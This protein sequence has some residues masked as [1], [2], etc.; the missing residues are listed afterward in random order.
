MSNKSFTT[1]G[2]TRQLEDKAEKLEGELGQIRDRHSDLEARFAEISRQLK[3]AQEKLEDV[4]NDSDAQRQHLKN[5]NE[6]LRNDRD[7]AER[8]CQTLLERA[9]DLDKRLRNESEEKDLLH[10]RHDTLTSESHALQ[11]DIAKANGRI[12]KLQFD[13]EQE[14]KCALENDKRLRNEAKVEFDR[15]TE[16]TDDACRRLE[17]KESQYISDKDYWEA[18]HRDLQSQKAKAEE[19]ANGLQ[20]TVDTLRESQ[21]TLPGKEMKLQ[22]A[23]ESEKKRHEDE[24]AVLLRQIQ[25]LKDDLAEKREDLETLRAEVAEA[26]DDLRI[27]ERDRLDLE[28]KVQELQDEVDVLQNGV[29][30]DENVNLQLNEVRE[31]LHQVEGDRQT[32]QEQLA[33]ASASSRDLHRALDQTEVERDELRS[34]TENMQAHFDKSQKLDQE[35]IELLSR[36]R[37][38]QNHILREKEHAE[39]CLNDHIRQ[40]ASEEARLVAERAE[41]ERKV[42]ALTKDRERDAA[43][44]KA[45][46]QRLQ[47][48]VEQLEG[49]LQHETGHDGASP[50]L[51]ILREDLSQ[52]RKKETALIQRE[53]TLRDSLRDLKRKVAELERQAHDSKVSRLAY[54]SPK[55]S[56]AESVRMEELNELRQQLNDSR[57]QLSDFRT[58]SRKAEETLQRKLIDAQR[59]E[60]AAL[61]A[62]SEQIEVLEEELRKCRKEKEQQEI[63]ASEAQNNEKRLQNRFKILETSLKS[64]HE[65][66]AMD[67]TMANERK[68][69]HEMLKSAKLE[70]EDLE[71]QV[72]A[73]DMQI[74]AYVRREKH[75]VR[76][77]R[78]AREERLTHEEKT[79]SLSSE[80]D[81]LQLEYDAALN[82]FSRK[83]KSL[84]AERK[85]ILGCARSTNLYQS[86]QDENQRIKPGGLGKV[87]Q[88]LNTKE[89]QHQL[90]LRGLMKQMQWLKERFMRESSFRENLQYE[91]RYLSLE[92]DMY[93][94]W[95]VP[96]LPLTFLNAEMSV[97][98]I[99]SISISWQRWCPDP[100]F[101][102]RRSPASKLPSS[103]SLLL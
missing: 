101:L 38:E 13:V 31:N 78:K 10:S 73:R 67:I 69:L 88:A 4:E 62:H 30:E 37:Q 56:V 41:L 79:I 33:L 57:H 98:A 36:L 24:E 8:K 82:K 74:K 14:K 9:Q 45:R 44:S 97:T 39:D 16:E 60:H 34:R 1:K 19:R 91:K 43:T 96:Y 52:A 27:T 54:G 75:L 2:L 51:S 71:L 32:L 55:S 15:L 61:Q 50:D 72:A 63:K 23:L 95:Y 102:S 3:D 81:R 85:A 76:D 25:E 92:I 6:L 35:K 87:E 103:W 89:K 53:S 21:G 18:Q 90:E 83:Q 11:K 64:A 94:S 84:E 29:E 12:E 5:E 59:Q 58:K 99:K 7:A 100:V 65:T 68:D 47:A 20:R 26:R 17:D 86:D 46:I 80:L 42:A 49:Q 28:E 48:Q 70:S 66:N 40:A 93:K 22:Q 77:L